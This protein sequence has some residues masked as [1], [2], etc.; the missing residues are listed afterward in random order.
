MKNIFVF[1]ALLTII[2]CNPQEEKNVVIN[3][4]DDPTLI[5]IETLQDKRD[6]DNLIEF[7]THENAQY[8]AAAA[9]AFA[10]IQDTA[11]IE[12]LSQLFNDSSAKVRKACAYALGQMY[13]EDA[14]VKLKE[15]LNVEDSVAVKKVLW[16]AMGKC[17]TKETLSYFTTM[18][19]ND[20]LEREGYAWGIYR[21]GLRGVQ[22]DTLVLRAVNLLYPNNSFESRFAAA[23]FL[24]RSRNIEIS[25]HLDSIIGSA[26][27]D[28]SPFVRMASTSALR[29]D[30]S[31]MTLR[32][33][34]NNIVKDDDYRVRINALR[35]M[36]R[37]ELVQIQ[38]AAFI[39][40]YDLH[41][42]FV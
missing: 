20:P 14:L 8:R 18:V 10:S 36:S 17:V 9:E 30:S 12:K 35:T 4:F 6:S 38:S 13:H 37:F 7:F 19:I 3:N 31:E 29:K 21:A 40:L 11:K 27:Y 5:Q 22:N 41:N 16:E 24:A 2:S 42:K 15:Q 23:H 34:T 26:L 39:A 25:A 28:K 33:I 1:L 32:T